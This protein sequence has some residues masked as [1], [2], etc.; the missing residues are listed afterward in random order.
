[1]KRYRVSAALARWTLIALGASAGHWAAAETNRAEDIV[2]SQCFVCH[3]MDGESS[4]PLFPR[5]AGQHA[6]YTAR[7]LADYKSGRRQNS[8]MQAMVRD[9]SGQDFEAL[10]RYF[11][12]RPVAAHTVADPA[13]AQSGQA[14]FERG[15][16]EAGVLAC[17]SCHGAQGHGTE[18]LPRLAG[19][20]ALYTEN[21]LKAFGQRQRR[22]DSGVMV[23]IASRLSPA[24]MKALASY[25][26][27]LK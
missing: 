26:S 6:A 16:P 5:L 3:G 27:G 24:E 4:T 22:N 11:E 25:I 15:K 17:S 20:H 18:N 9:L 8:V 23:Q 12:A 13:L 10:G 21:Q 19:Q 1:M 14:L 2:Q 7:Q